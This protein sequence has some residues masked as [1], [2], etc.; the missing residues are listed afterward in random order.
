M[1]TLLPTKTI[2]TSWKFWLFDFKIHIASWA[3]A[4]VFIWMFISQSYLEIFH[5]SISSFVPQIIQIDTPFSGAK[6]QYIPSSPPINPALTFVGNAT[7]KM[8][9][10]R[11]IAPGE[12]FPYYNF[13]FTGAIPEYTGSLDVFKRN[14]GTFNPGELS[15]L[16]TNFQIEGLNFQAFEKIS[17]TNLTL[18]EARDFGYIVSID[19]QNGTITLNQN[20]AKWPQS[21]CTADGC[22]LPT[23]LEESDMSSDDTIIQ[24]GNDFLKKY[25]LDEYHMT[26]PQLDKNWKIYY[27]QAKKESPST[28]QIPEQVTLTYPQTIHGIRIYDEYGTY[29]WLSLAFDVRNKQ[30]AS[31]FGFE[32]QS[33]I[34]A[35]YTE[36]TDTANIQQIIRYGWRYQTQSFS[37]Q[38]IKEASLASPSIGYVRLWWETYEA[39]GR[40]REF[41]V[42][43]YVF[44][45]L[46]EEA[47]KETGRENIV[48]PLVKD[49]AEFYPIDSSVSSNPIPTPLMVQ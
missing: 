11:M 10:D 44:P 39:D 31:M 47:R 3:L 36:M 42:P 49:F 29:K 17:I 24:I 22:D 48:V 30:I 16:F 46:S 8:E 23:K 19:L 37:G 5:S 26:T 35:K 6:L 45:I 20:W 4:C 25:G 34:Q 12:Q 33:L 15:S 41:Y 18:S 21:H 27:A 13:T 1:S 38:K 43:A 32:K 40:G 14:G 2:K 9:N 7:M 28:A